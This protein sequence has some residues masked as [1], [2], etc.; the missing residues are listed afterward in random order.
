MTRPT[1]DEYRRLFLPV[2]GSFPSL[3][4]TAV[5]LCSG[6]KIKLGVVLN[7]KGEI[8]LELEKVG[9]GEISEDSNLVEKRLTKILS[10]FQKYVQSQHSS[11]SG[12]MNMYT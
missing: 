9:T 6:N 5:D 4:D 10:F 2:L 1:R 3:L 8:E 11:S 12:G 7:L